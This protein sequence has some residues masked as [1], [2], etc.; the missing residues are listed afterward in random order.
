MSVAVLCDFDDTAAEQNVAHLL[1]DRFKG[2][3]WRRLLKRFRDGTIP[4]KEYF[5][6]P[7]RAIAATRREM[8]TH[9]REAASLRYGFAE[10]ADYCAR[11]GVELAIVTHG[12]DFYVQAL[13]EHNGLGWV[14]TYPVNAHF[15]PAG[16]RFEYRYTKPGC[17]EWGNCKCTV[18]E[19]YAKAE[20]RVLYVGDG[21]SDFCPARK[22]DLVVART[23][24]LEMCREEGLLHHELRDFTDVIKALEGDSHD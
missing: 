7:F 2:D 3:G 20:Y 22:A 5:E 4:P 9:V 19:R 13:L 24:L 16:I 14:P 12:L 1:L 6:A 23:G 10:L 15:T 8:Q 18:V 11:N 21:A 17:Q